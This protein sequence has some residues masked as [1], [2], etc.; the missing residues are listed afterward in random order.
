MMEQVVRQADNQN[1]H[2]SWP[3]TCHCLSMTVGYDSKG[4]VGLL[5]KAPEKGRPR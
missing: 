1:A 5:K 3:L 4:I 2:S